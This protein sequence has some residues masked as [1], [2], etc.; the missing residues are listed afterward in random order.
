MLKEHLAPE[1]L[2]TLDLYEQYALI[3][4]IEV[5]KQSRSMAAA[6]RA[7]FNVSRTQKSSKNDSH[8]IKQL[9]ERY[10]LNFETLKAQ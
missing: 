9:L 6:G 1:T 4:V 2:S 3:G 10:G 5:C 7:L 8:R